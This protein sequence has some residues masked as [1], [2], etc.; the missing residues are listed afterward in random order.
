[1]KKKIMALA[2]RDFVLYNFRQELLDRLIKEDC[3]VYIC[4]PDGPKIKKMIEAGCVHIPI[5]IDKRGKNPVKDLRLLHNYERI[6]REIKPDL[7]L[8]YTTKVC[9]YGG[10]VAGHSGI[11]YLVNVSGLGTALDHKGPLQPLMIRLYRR[12]CRHAECVFFQNTENQRFFCEHRIYKGKQILIPGSGV[13]LTKW[14]YLEYPG[15]VDGLEFLFAARLIKEKGIEEY[16]KCARQ[17]KRKYPLVKFHVCGPCD[18]GYEEVLQK[19]EQNG[20]ILYHGEVEDLGVYLKQV[21]CLIHPSYYPE[22]I[23][24]V[25]LEAAASGRPVITTDRSGLRETVDDNLTGY[26]FEAPN[27]EQLA[28]CVEKFIRLT[29][30]ERREMGLKGR[31]KMEKE[32][33]RQMVVDAYMQEIFRKWGSV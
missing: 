23:S 1:M 2:N 14:K 26:L 16:L 9:I 13:N 30:K 10:I 19:Y 27:T 24:N 18:G 22:G 21:H 6:C 5:G 33:D 3:E 15:D 28:L 17:I 31:Q 7:L 32:F 20:D 11:P 29:Q 8:L 4:L 12:A 25:C